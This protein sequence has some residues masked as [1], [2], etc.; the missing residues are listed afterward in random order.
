MAIKT[1]ARLPNGAIVLAYR[2][3]CET[4]VNDREYGI[5]LGFARVSQDPFMTW[6]T[7]I[8]EGQIFT[9]HGHYFETIWPALQDFDERKGKIR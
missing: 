3:T 6:D 1:G 8:E 7:A 5:V 4:G 2:T 9:S